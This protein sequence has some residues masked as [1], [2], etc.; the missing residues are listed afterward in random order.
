MN[1]WKLCSESMVRPHSSYIDV[2][3][4]FTCDSLHS[5]SRGCLSDYWN[6]FLLLQPRPG[7]VQLPLVFS[8]SV[9]RS[10]QR[11]KPE[12]FQ[13]SLSL[14]LGI[15]C[16]IQIMFL[17][18]VCPFIWNVS[19]SVPSV[20][21]LAFPVSQSFIWGGGQRSRYFMQTTYLRVCSNLHDTPTLGNLSKHYTKSDITTFSFL[22]LLYKHLWY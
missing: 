14:A 6:L 12:P 7:T 11:L 4:Y 20:A 16:L 1:H 9:F 21:L 19:A 5:R 17:F 13:N 15:A 22:F 18:D 2:L 3:L 8:P 10:E